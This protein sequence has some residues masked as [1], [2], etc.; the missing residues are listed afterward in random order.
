M[1]LV[2]GWAD[3]T[4]LSVVH[5]CNDNDNGTSSVICEIGVFNHSFSSFL[6]LWKVTFEVSLFRVDK[7]DEKIRVRTN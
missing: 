4:Y 1:K 2:A 6:Y 3:L 5:P 7:F